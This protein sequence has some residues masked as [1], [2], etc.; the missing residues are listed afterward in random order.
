MSK[1]HPEYFWLFCRASLYIGDFSALYGLSQF[2]V[3]ADFFGICDLPAIW[4]ECVC[5]SKNKIAIVKNISFV[6]TCGKCLLSYKVSEL[7]ENTLCPICIDSESNERYARLWRPEH[8]I[9]AHW[10]THFMS[11]DIY[12]FITT[13]CSLIRKIKP[14][15]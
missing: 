1:F 6:N 7:I 15:Y 14:T 12:L 3:I 13:I 5:T 9:L 8:I 4:T 2:K 11:K 10:S